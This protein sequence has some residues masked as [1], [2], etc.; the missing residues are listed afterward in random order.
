MHFIKNQDVPFPQLREK[1]DL[2]R[3]QKADKEVLLER[4]FLNAI[5]FFRLCKNK[6]AYQ[7]CV[8]PLYE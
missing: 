7:H 6:N 1:I 3:S 5:G 4:R 8:A 2:N